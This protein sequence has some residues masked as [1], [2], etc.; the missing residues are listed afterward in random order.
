MCY[1]SH[2]LRIAWDGPALRKELYQHQLSQQETSILY[3]SALRKELYPRQAE[4]QIQ[5][6]AVFPS[7]RPWQPLPQALRPVE[8]TSDQS[9]KSGTPIP[10]TPGIGNAAKPSS[11]LP[12]ELP[13]RSPPVAGEAFNMLPPAPIPEAKAPS[14]LRTLETRPAG[15]ILVPARFLVPRRL[16]VTLLCL[17][18]LI[19]MS[20][21]GTWL[22][23][24]QQHQQHAQEGVRPQLS[25]LALLQQRLLF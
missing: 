7:Q 10:L 6:P 9:E 18:L 5:H 1:Q 15:P 24:A 2:S 4:Q 20:G 14:A 22:Y 19:S 16:L 17:L 11:P 25:P 8:H 13:L 3:G 21:G 23:L 12:A